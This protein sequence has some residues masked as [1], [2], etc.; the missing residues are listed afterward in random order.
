MNSMLL[1]VNKP[2]SESLVGA[3][4]ETSSYPAMDSESKTSYIDTGRISL[5]LLVRLS[6]YRRI[7]K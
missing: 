7:H 2:E 1:S 4:E 5:A 3:K 6:V